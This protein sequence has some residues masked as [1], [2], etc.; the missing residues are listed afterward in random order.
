MRS[1]LNEHLLARMLKLFAD[2]GQLV[3][4]QRKVTTGII[5]CLLLIVSLGFSAAAQEFTPWRDHTPESGDAVSRRQGVCEQ[6]QALVG[7]FG[8]SG[9]LIDT[10]NGVLCVPVMA[11]G[12]WAVSTPTRKEVYP[13]RWGGSDFTLQCPVDQGVRG[14]AGRAG[15]GASDS[16]RTVVDALSLLCGPLGLDSE[17]SVAVTAPGSNTSTV[18]GGG[19]NAFSDACPPGKMGWAIEV[20]HRPRTGS[21]NQLYYVR[22]QCGRVLGKPYDVESVTLSADA[23][24]PGDSATVTVT[25]KGPAGAQD[26]RILNSPAYTVPTFFTATPNWELPIPVG[27]RTV[28]ATITA[29]TNA[30]PGS[31]LVVKPTRNG[32]QT[33][34]PEKTLTVKYPNAVFVQSVTVNPST[35]YEG[36]SAT[37]TV[38]LTG[39]APSLGAS[40]NITRQGPA[41]LNAPVT[42]GVTDNMLV[43]PGSQSVSATLTWNSGT[44]SGTISAKTNQIG[45]SGKTAQYIVLP[46]AVKS[47]TLVNDPKSGAKPPAGTLGGGSNTV[48]IRVTLELPAGGGGRTVNLSKSKP[49]IDL[50]TTVQIPAGQTSATFTVTKTASTGSTRVRASIAGAGSS[51]VKDLLLEW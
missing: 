25:L 28:T 31:Q 8:R 19:G 43:M 47:L 17:G 35:F 16:P 12:K 1:H 3:F 30:Q 26:K 14:L 9:T 4:A 33:Q 5:R 48:S 13:E 23:I 6:G 10:V 50:P 18:G 46:N 42:A 29:N 39:P 21:Q 20:L 40:L 44:G 7:I 22:M 15:T 32:Y 27:A 2:G 36:T 37:V 24:A 38:T 11:D 41:W 49:G 51:V 34:S 45:D